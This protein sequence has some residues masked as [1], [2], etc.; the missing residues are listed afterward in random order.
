MVKETEMHSPSGFIGPFFDHVEI[1]LLD[2]APRAGH[3]LPPLE[4]E[5][6]LTSN[7]AET[8]ALTIKIDLQRKKFVS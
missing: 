2:F 6:I 3:D 7:G 4:H 1:V 8:L 5:H